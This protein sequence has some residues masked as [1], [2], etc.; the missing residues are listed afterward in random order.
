L[1]A[2]QL[3]WYTRFRDALKFNGIER[4]EVVRVYLPPGE[5]EFACRFLNVE[6]TFGG[7]P[8]VMTEGPRRYVLDN[9][10]EIKY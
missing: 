2:S 3:P 6:G 4:W 1:F 5:Y 9:G 8:F 10:D 7:I